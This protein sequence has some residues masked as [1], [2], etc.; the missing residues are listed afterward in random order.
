MRVPDTPGC[1]IRLREEAFR[2]RYLP[3]AWIVGDIDVP[4]AW[5]PTQDAPA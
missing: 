3:A 2:E 5:N 1:G 4:A